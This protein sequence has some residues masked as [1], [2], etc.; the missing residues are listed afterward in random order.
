M[1]KSILLLGK[2]HASKTVFLSQLY[3]KLKKNKSSLKLYK[4]VE[5]LSP[6]AEARDSLASG[7]GP[8]TTPAEKS[9]KFY[10]PLQVNDN[11]VDLKCPEY[12]GEQV[13]DIME[14]REL[15]REWKSSIK[16][17][18]NW[19][20]FIRLNNIGN[21]LDI[22]DST[23]KENPAAKGNKDLETFEYHISDQSFF[24][25]L[26]Q[27]IMNE[28]GTD[29]HLL[30]SD[31]KLTVVLTCWDEMEVKGNPSPCSILKD[32]LPLLLDFAES[33][34]DRSSLKILGLSAQEF[35]LDS[36]DNQE[37]YMIEGPENFGY[38]ILEDGTRS[39]DITKL[40]ELAIQ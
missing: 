37:K 13:L 35:N 22:A 40:I 1:P 30:N 14:S 4:P 27:I 6:I 3:S 11:Q 20:L 33:N 23:Y 29:F 12:G 17:S 21:R 26:L 18:D 10:L 39:E 28:K 2:P 9:V 36:E 8:V 5:D 32:K 38:L 16:E 34:W 7:K 25:E 19:V 31:I 15:N 24:I